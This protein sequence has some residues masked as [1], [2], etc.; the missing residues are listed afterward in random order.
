M[1]KTRTLLAESRRTLRQA[2]PLIGAQLLQVGNGLVDALV[3]G[4]LGREALAASGVAAALWFFTSLLCIGLMAGLSPILSEMIGQRRR[5][6]VGFVF[7]Q[8]LWLGLLVG[9]VATTSLV[10]VA[11]SLQH[12]SLQ[13]ELIPL[14]RQYLLPASLSLPAFAVVMASRNLCE[15]TGLT[16]PVLLVTF[17][18]LIINI[19]GDLC[20]G[21]GWLGFPKLGLTGIGWST[22]AVMISMAVALLWILKRRPRFQRYNLFSSFE[23]PQAREIT[24]ILRLAIPIFLGLCFEAGLFTATIMQMAMI[25]TLETAAHNIALGITSF[26]YMLPLGLSFALTARIGRAYGHQKIQAIKLRAF[27]GLLLTIAM[28][29]TTATLILLFRHPVTALY[30][31][32]SEVRSFAAQLLLFAAVFQLSDAAQ[33]TLIGML[34]GLQDT[35]VPMLINLFS[36]WVIA[37]GLGYVSTNHLGFGAYGLWFGLITGLTLSACL[38]LVRLRFRLRMLTGRLEC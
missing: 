2:A 36:Y 4:R 34:R 24:R 21:L 27:T 10:I 19:L 29:A 31:S 13:S 6:A 11:T 17:I 33:A 25:G 28:A 30:T 8:G 22:T 35:K 20:F 1:I 12:T 32:D 7:R 9:L 16:R 15:A 26:C 3:A 14:I 38:L 18:G 37:F 23:R 5:A